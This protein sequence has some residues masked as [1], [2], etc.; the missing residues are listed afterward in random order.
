[1]SAPTIKRSEYVE[2]GDRELAHWPGV[3]AVR[4]PSRRHLRLTL[5]FGGA[6]R[7]VIAPMTGSDVK[8]PLNH[9]RD[10]RRTLREMGAVRLAR[11]KPVRPERKPVKPAA[12]RDALTLPSPEPLRRDPTRDPF[13]VLAGMQLSQPEPADWPPPAP[14]APLTPQPDVGWSLVVLAAV[15][16]GLALVMAALVADLGGLVTP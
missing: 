7:F 12:G 8:G 15:L 14:P 11:S 2:F 13:A 10:I 5:T 9:V 1:M 4:R 16:T 6:S 3:E